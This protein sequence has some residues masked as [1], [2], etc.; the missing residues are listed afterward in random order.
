MTLQDSLREHIEAAFTGL[1]IQS[2]EHEDALADIADLC[3]AEQWQLA[4]WD[5]EQGLRCA[6]ATA[7]ITPSAND[8]LAAIRSAK[9]LVADDG[10]AVLVLVNFH[11]FL[12]SAEIVQA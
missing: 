12:H 4:V 10:S 5:L 1:W 8:P 11:R 7:E 6:G 3:R 9:T 2:H